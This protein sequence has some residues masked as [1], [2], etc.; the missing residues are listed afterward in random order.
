[1]VQYRE[2]V[3]E[4]ESEEGQRLAERC[5]RRLLSASGDSFA[6]GNTCEFQETN[7]HATERIRTFERNGI[8]EF[9]LLMFRIAPFLDRE[10]VNRSVDVLILDDDEVG[11]LYVTV[12]TSNL[13]LHLDLAVPI[14]VTVEP[15]PATR[16][17][18]TYLRVTF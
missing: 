17:L 16:V 6:C 9:I 4:M 3:H 15:L 10:R 1:M 18:E 12:P 11:Q 7:E 2:R 8:V 14:V 5:M 13:C